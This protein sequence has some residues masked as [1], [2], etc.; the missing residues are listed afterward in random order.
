VVGVAATRLTIQNGAKRHGVP[1]LVALAAV[2]ALTV[3]GSHAGA[4]N[5]GADPAPTD[6]VRCLEDDDPQYWKS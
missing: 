6:A 2:L 1:T 5:I 4:T 3:P